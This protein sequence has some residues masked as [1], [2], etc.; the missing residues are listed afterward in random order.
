MPTLAAYI[1]LL[2]LTELSMKIRQIGGI[3][4]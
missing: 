2:M 3:M 4:Y 1:L